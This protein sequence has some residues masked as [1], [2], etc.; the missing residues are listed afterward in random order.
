MKADG[1]LFRQAKFIFQGPDPLLRK[2]MGVSD[3]NSPGEHH[4]GSR[5]FF[6]RRVKNRAC[7]GNALNFLQGR[8]FALNTV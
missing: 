2:V 8:N 5:L 6:R 4:S 7:Q 3:D 1:F